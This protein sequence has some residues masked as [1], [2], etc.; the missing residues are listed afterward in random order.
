MAEHSWLFLVPVPCAPHH[1]VPS[2]SM[3]RLIGCDSYGILV[4]QLKLISVPGTGLDTVS[5]ILV[6]HKLPLT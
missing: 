3:I 5:Y 6:L 1:S 2:H 4:K